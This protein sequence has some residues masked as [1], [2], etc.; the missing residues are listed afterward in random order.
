MKFGQ[1]IPWSSMRQSVRGFFDIPN[2]FP[3]TCS[4]VTKIDK[5]C[6]R[7]AKLKIDFLR[8]QSE[9]S[10]RLNRLL[11]DIVQFVWSCA[12]AG[13]QVTD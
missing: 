11:F 10:K 5:S 2:N 1:N 13:R 8:N 12:R 3:F 9:Y 4:H 6:I 7:L